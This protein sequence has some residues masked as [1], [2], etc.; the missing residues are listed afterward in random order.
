MML[1]AERLV[2][3][4][5]VS[6]NRFHAEHAVAA[7]RHGA[8]VLLEKPPVLSMEEIRAVRKAKVQNK[9]Q[10]IVGFSNRFTRG[11]R[12]IRKMLAEGTIGEPY[13]VRIRFAHTGP[14]AGWAK[15]DWFYDPKRAGGGALLDM[16]IHAIDLALWLIGPVRRVTAMTRSLRYGIRVDDNAVLALEVAGGRALGYIEAGWTSPSGFIG[17]EIMGDGGCIVE[18]YQGALR[19]AR[20]RVT[21]DATKRPKFKWRVVDPEPTWGGWR[22]EIGEVVRALRRGEDLGMGID[23][24]GAARAVARAGCESSRSGRT[25]EVGGGATGRRR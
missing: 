15:S 16:G 9:R 19:V 1:K 12:K 2:V 25:V 14:M 6:P 18:D 20:G 7:L 10:V 4:S 17:L 11:N 23:A 8:H 22:V 21:P 13:M 3:V 24:G 5:V